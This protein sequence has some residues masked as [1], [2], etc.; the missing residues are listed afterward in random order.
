MF[1]NW[2]ENGACGGE[3]MKANLVNNY[4]KPGPATALTPEKVQH[5]IFAVGVRTEA[6]CYE[7]DKETGAIL[8]DKRMN[9]IRCCMCGENISSTAM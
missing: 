4:Y 6:D 1:Y 9:G 2:G 8:P 5:R 3:G 7:V